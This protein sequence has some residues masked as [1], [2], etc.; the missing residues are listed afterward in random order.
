MKT[1]K[2]SLVAL[3]TVLT[4]GAAAQVGIQAGYSSESQKTTGT[5]LGFTASTTTTLNGFHVGPII[6]MNVQG[7]VGF[8]TGLLYNYLT[9]TGVNNKKIVAHEIDLPVRLTVAFPVSDAVSVFAFGGPNVNYALS[10]KT[11]GGDNIY[12]LKNP[13]NNDKKILSPFDFQLGVGGGLKWNK[14]TL[15][16]GYDW[17]MFNKTS[18]DNATFKSNVLKA[19]VAYNF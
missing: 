13:L 16:A 14:L 8:Q 5:I 7:P 15:K 2:L 3:A 18:I 1:I 11:D 4:M 17:G 19:A 6:D 12:S 9:G 10:Q